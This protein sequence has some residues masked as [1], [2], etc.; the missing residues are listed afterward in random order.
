MAAH[1]ETLI[2]QGMLINDV[3]FRCDV[4]SISRLEGL[5]RGFERG[6]VG[7]G[8]KTYKTSAGVDIPFTTKEH[9]ME[10][11]NAA[12]DHRD[13]ILERSAQIQNM[14]P[15]PDPSDKTLWQ[16]PAL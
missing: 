9:V 3:Q 4:D 11:L 7:P 12:D 5:V 15:I 2:N 13:W 8:G 14:D 10:V 6:A 1:A 16:K